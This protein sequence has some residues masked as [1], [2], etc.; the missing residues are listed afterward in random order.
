MN[1]FDISEPDDIHTKFCK[2]VAGVQKN[3]KFCSTL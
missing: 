1:I 3:I 2:Y